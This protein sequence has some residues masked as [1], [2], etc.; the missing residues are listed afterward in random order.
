MLETKIRAELQTKPILLMTH[1]VL[2]YPSFEENEKVIGAMAQA[3]VEL[4]ELQIPFSEPSADGP[5]IVNANAE[6]LAK[7]TKVEQCFEFAAKMTGLYPKVGFL[8]MTYTNILFARGMDQFLERSLAA[9]LQGFIIPDL[10]IEE[11]QDWRR[12]CHKAQM[13]N[14]LIMTPTSTEAR[15]KEIGQASTGLVYSVGRRGV[16]GLKT[17]FDLGLEAQIRRFKAAT[18][19]PLALGFGVKSPEDVAFLSGK[20]DLAVIGSKLI[21]LHQEAGVEAVGRFLGSLR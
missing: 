17:Q 14:V 5:V 8:F 16:T 4:V 18:K 15:L 6:S 12:N 19:L 7:G 21:E 13:A 11:S 3:G 2:G 20:A 9:G 1:L 10:P